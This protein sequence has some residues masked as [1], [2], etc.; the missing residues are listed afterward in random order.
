M[1]WLLKFLYSI[2]SIFQKR[3]PF[4]TSTDLETNANKQFYRTT[5]SDCSIFTAVKGLNLKLFLGLYVVP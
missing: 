5:C 4:S 3:L 2:F 1:Y